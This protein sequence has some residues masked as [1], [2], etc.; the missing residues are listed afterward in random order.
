MRVLP[1]SDENKPYAEKVA[2]TLAENGI[3]V[4]RD[5][6]SGTIGGKIRDA[7]LQKVP[8]MLVI[9]AKEEQAGLGRGQ[10]A[11]TGTSGTA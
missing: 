10:G 3:R 4:E 11:G 6:A 8:Y 9:G 2:Q 7:Q 5:F 1:V